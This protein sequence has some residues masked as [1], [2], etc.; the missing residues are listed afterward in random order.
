ML[1]TLN[2]GKC[3]QG[4]SKITDFENFLEKLRK[5]LATAAPNFF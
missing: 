5:F 1:V 4:E 2:A 3:N